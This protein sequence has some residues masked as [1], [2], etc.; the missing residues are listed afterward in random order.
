MTTVLERPITFDSVLATVAAV[1][2]L[3]PHLRRVTF[4]APRIA[5]AVTAGPDQR[6]KVLL[7]PPDGSEIKLPTGPEWYPEWCAQ[8]VEERF[9][10]RT[11]TIRALRP[12][13]SELDVEFVLHGINGP[14][15]AWVSEAKPGDQIG[16]ILPFA[17][18]TTSTKGLLHSG[19]DYVPPATSVR[20]VLVADETAL[21]ALAGIL[22]QLPAAVHATVFVEVPDVADIRPLPTPGTADITWVAPGQLLEA[23]KAADLPYDAD[24]AWVAGESSM[25]KSVRRHLVNTVGMPKSAISFQGY[26]KRGEAQI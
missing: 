23:L 10:M 21:P 4:V 16:L 12:E 18:D 2:D 6:I 1:D 17:V 22:E 25:I 24:Y 20:R 8:P 11:Y 9:I 15:S 7:S 19:V 3:S 13:I 26:W 14:A 5:D